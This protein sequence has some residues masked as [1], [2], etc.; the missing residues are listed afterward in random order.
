[1][2]SI[3]SRLRALDLPLPDDLVVRATAA[4]TAAPHS[5]RRSQTIARTLAIGTIASAAFLGANAASAQLWPAYGRLL[6]EAPGLRD[7]PWWFEPSIGTAPQD[8]TPIDVSATSA[9]HTVRIIGA[10]ADGARTML[11]FEIDGKR[12]DSDTSP[13]EFTIFGQA[14]LTDSEGNVYRQLLYGGG[15]VGIFEP[16]RG[17]AAQGAAVTL[18]ITQ[19]HPRDPGDPVAGDWTLTFSMTADP[20]LPVAIPAPIT[21]EGTTYTV[22][23]LRVSRE[24]IEVRWRATG[25]AVDQAV[26]HEAAAP[27]WTNAP[28]A[29]LTP[30]PITVSPEFKAHADQ[31]RVLNAT[32][33]DPTLLAPSGLIERPFS[34]GMSAP[35]DGA[36]EGDATIRLTGAGRYRL[37]FGEQAEMILEIP[38]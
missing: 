7:I 6:A 29:M 23:S 33:F 19:L 28:S 37:R 16:L 17:A 22:T 38:K 5:P 27:P 12:Y 26:A 14:T 30:G 32:F 36:V 10:S 18:H 3:E 31:R 35:R 11:F 20:A 8:V 24:V 21:V 4:A 34:G 13:V 25:A 15:L 9:G 1:M 2:T